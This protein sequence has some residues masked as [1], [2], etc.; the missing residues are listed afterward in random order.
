MK[1]I[2]NLSDQYSNLISKFEHQGH[3]LVFKNLNIKQKLTEDCDIILYNTYNKRVSTNIIE[4]L[5]KK[6]KTKKLIILSDNEMANSSLNEIKECMQQNCNYVDSFLFC[7]NPLSNKK[8]ECVG[9]INRCWLQGQEVAYFPKKAYTVTPEDN[10]YFYFNA[11]FGTPTYNKYKFYEKLQS[12]KL[13][14]HRKVAYLCGSMPFL[15]KKEANR[16]KYLKEFNLTINDIKN[17]QIIIDDKIINKE[18]MNRY[19]IK[20]GLE[21]TSEPNQLYMMLN[22]RFTL[23][24]ESESYNYINRYTEKSMKPIAIHQPFLIRGNY[25]VLDLLKKDGFKTFHPFIN[26]SYDNIE[27][28]IERDDFIIKEVKRLMDLPLNKW[29]HLLIEMS[30]ILDHNY[31]HLSTLHKKYENILSRHISGD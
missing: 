3:E 28:D 19:L 6:L 21:P 26:E 1:I 17:K 29:K 16:T 8:D 20:L 2:H 31:K 15:A 9:Y 23:T 10:P 12:S 5:F 18:N 22:S 13:L 24:I 25:K 27:N 14:P 11:T 7:Q 4:S 30:S